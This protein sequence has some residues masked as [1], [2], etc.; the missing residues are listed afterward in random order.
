MALYARRH[1][2]QRRTTLHDLSDLERYCYYVAGTVGHL[3]TDVFLIGAPQT[4]AARRLRQHAEGFG[5]LLQ[6]TNIVKDV[7]DDAK[8]LVL[9][10]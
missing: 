1:A 7:T 2:R 10:P 5:L 6:M 4:Q 9:H 8:R 3:L